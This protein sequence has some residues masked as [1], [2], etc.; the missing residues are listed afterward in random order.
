MPP[1]KGGPVELTLIFGIEGSVLSARRAD[2]QLSILPFQTQ[3]ILILFNLRIF[4]VP[5]NEGF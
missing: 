5:F 3:K 2:S 1:K 4:Q